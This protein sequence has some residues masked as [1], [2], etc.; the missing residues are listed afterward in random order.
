MPPRI[1]KRE[2]RGL[3]CH[4]C[5]RQKVKSD[6]GLRLSKLQ[7]DIEE[8]HIKSQ[9]NPA[10]TVPCQI[11]NKAT[12]T[13]S[14][15][16][17]LE[18]GGLLAAE[19]SGRSSRRIPSD[20]VDSPRKQPIQHSD[21]NFGRRSMELLGENSTAEHFVSKLKEIQDL[22]TFLCGQGTRLDSLSII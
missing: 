3:A 22:K 16:K 20:T 15:L 6:G 8:S 13:E 1:N 10:G 9:R 18:G 2:Y 21:P 7:R 11:G 19:T 5:H 12:V 4:R 17:K 14:Y